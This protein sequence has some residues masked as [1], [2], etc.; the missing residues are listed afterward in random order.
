[1]CECENSVMP[2]YRTLLERCAGKT[3]LLHAIA[4]FS[5]PDV[6][7]TVKW[8]D[9]IVNAIDQHLGEL[10]KRLDAAGIPL[11]IIGDDEGKQYFTLPMLSSLTRGE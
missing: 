10:E 9:D 7:A 1:M 5:G 4:L 2:R 6:V 11:A 3:E 8:F